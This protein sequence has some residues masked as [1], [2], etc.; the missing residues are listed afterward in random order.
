MQPEDQTIKQKMQHKNAADSQNAYG[1]SAN[2]P[3]K[4]AKSRQHTQKTPCREI[5]NDL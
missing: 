2:K 3:G 4:P 5:V 1:Q